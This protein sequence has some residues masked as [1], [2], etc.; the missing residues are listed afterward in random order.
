MPAKSAPACD[1]IDRACR[2]LRVFLASSSRARRS[3]PLQPLPRVRGDA[4]L[5]GV[6]GARRRPTCSIPICRRGR[7]CGSRR[8]R[9]C[10]PRLA[11]ASRAAAPPFPAGPPRLAARRPRR[12]ARRC[13]RRSP[14][15]RARPRSRTCA[16][17]GGPSARCSTRSSPSGLDP[18]FG[19]KQLAARIDLQI[20]RVV[21]GSTKV[22]DRLRREVLYYVAI[23]AP[24]APSVRE[25]QRAFRLA[26]LI[27]L[28][29]GA[30][31][32]RAAPRAAAARRRASRSARPRMPGSSSRRAAR[33]T[34]RS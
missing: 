31:G 8:R 19:V 3:S 26:E 9:P 34:C 30:V 1:A 27:P 16:R 24:V 25:V 32:R 6:Q 5:R 23:S 21:E 28:G 14:A 11:V 2:K 29:R 20:R 22:A 12:G 4:A 10:R 17:S 33:R 13:A 18:G 7:R 15:S